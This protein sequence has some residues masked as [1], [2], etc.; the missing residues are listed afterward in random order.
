MKPPPRS[1]R[2]F[3]TCDATRIGR[4]SVM[5]RIDESARALAATLKDDYKRGLTQEIQEH[6]V[7]IYEACL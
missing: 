7:K 6:V 5:W 1:D 4:A 3:G 2:V